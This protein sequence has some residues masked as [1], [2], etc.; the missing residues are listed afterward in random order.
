M[1]ESLVNPRRV[2][3]GPWKM[4]FIGLLYASLSLILVK[5][6]FASDAVLVNYSGLI[7]VTF[8]VMFSLPFMYFIIRQEEAEDEEISGG[9][10]RLWSVHKDALFSLIWLFLGFVV[11][12]SFWFL[13]LQD[14]NLL[15]AQIETYCSINSPDSV[16]ECVSQYVNG[17]F[18]NSTGYATGGAHFLKI[19]ENN[20][21]VMLFTLLFS[22]I[23]GAGAIFVLAWNATVIASAVG[24]FT[25]FE[26]SQIPFGLLRYMIHGLP[27]II[28]YFLAALA[29]GIVGTGIIRNDL[30]SKR[31]LHVIENAVIILFV[32]ILVLVV[33]GIMEVYLTPLF[34]R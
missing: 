24:I 33:A 3:K 21:Y 25:K 19:L 5:L 9:I 14:T 18:P 16:S 2:E 22:L 8:C 11:A 17:N 13:V 4:F 7:V 23:F 27:E 26:L 32:A 1:L 15:N 31:F 6:F 12:F 20:L 34:F 10:R 29:G 28:T 30:N